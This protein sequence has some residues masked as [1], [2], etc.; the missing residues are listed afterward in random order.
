MSAFI[1]SP[2]HIKQLA[3]FAARK[4]QGSRNVDPRYLDRNKGLAIADGPR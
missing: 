1:V 4:S 3:L 2:E